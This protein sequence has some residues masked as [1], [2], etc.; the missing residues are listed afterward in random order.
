MGKLK[1]LEDKY[2]IFLNFIDQNDLPEIREKKSG[3]AEVREHMMSELKCGCVRSYTVVREDC[4]R[5]GFV[6]EVWPVIKFAQS[7]YVKGQNKPVLFIDNLAYFKQHISD[8]QRQ[9]L[10]KKVNCL[11]MS[12]L[13]R[14]YNAYLMKVKFS[15]NDNAVWTPTWKIEKI[16]ETL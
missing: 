16:D 1:S 4:R 12:E 14:Q 15:F 10:A 8:A 3:L 9:V 2:V 5:N 13:Y 7:Q 11:S 6:V